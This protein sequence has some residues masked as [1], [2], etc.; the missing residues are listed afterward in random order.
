MTEL[1]TTLGALEA[2]VSSYYDR[3]AY[4]DWLRTHSVLVGRIALVLAEAR[5]RAGDAVDVETVALA[6]YLHDVGKS[7]LTGGDGHR[8]HEWSALVLAAEGLPGLVEPARRHVVF[9]VLDPALAP[10]N[11]AERIVYVADRRGG[12]RV[13]TIAER[14]ADQAQ[15]FPDS[16]DAIERCRPIAEAMERELFAG[17]DFGPG[18]LAARLP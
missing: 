7:P 16:A 14:L 12:V 2:R 10:R 17:C 13:Q 5:R 9:S 18:D 8:H 6:G 4:P 3:Y 15:R 1:S 11:L